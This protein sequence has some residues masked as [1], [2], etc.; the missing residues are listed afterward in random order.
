MIVRTLLTLLNCIVFA[1][2]IVV[3]LYV[4]KYVTLTFYFLL[5]WMV[6]SFTLFYLPFAGRRLGGGTPPATENN[7][8]VTSA[9]GGDAPPS[10]P[11]SG[12]SNFGFCIYCAAP[13]AGGATVCPACG[14]AVPRF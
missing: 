13:L 3:L 10:A 4:P 6:V 12:T 7:P 9:R 5:A 14:H 1:F 11:P 8:F 2:T